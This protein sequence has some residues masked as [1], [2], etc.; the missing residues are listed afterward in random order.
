MRT[1]ARAHYL[2]VQVTRWWQI[3]GSAQFWISGEHWLTFSLN[4]HDLDPTLHLFS[5][6]KV[7]FYALDRIPSA[8][9]PT[10]SVTSEVVP[11]ECQHEVTTSCLLHFTPSVLIITLLN[12]FKRII[13]FP[14]SSGFSVEDFESGLLEFSGFIKLSVR[15]WAF[16]FRWQ[17]Q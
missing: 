13:S 6:S 10:I 9:S 11:K 14:S 1:S 3:W 16:F 12:G 15:T 4:S 7:R 5:A 8:Q 17:Q 2:K